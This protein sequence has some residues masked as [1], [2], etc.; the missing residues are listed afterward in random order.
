MERHFNLVL[1]TMMTNWFISFTG[2]MLYPKTFRL[3]DPITLW[4]EETADWGEAFP[5]TV[6]INFSYYDCGPSSEERPTKWLGLKHP[7]L[8]DWQTLP[9]ETWRKCWNIQV[10]TTL[11]TVNCRQISV[12]PSSA[13]DTPVPTH[14]NHTVQGRCVDGRSRGAGAHHRSF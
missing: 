13:A 8:I 11:Q 4:C 5:C 10:M 9:W 1:E 2:F 7:L 3:Y 6:S 14:L 12:S